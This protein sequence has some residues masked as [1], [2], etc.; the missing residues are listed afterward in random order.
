[1]R[2]D[3]EKEAGPQGKLNCIIAA[4]DFSD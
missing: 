3:S 4:L 1:M 2:Q